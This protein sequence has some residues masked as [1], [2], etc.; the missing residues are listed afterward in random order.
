MARSKAKR[1]TRPSDIAVLRAHLG[2]DD[3]PM[4]FKEFGELLGVSE[5][6]AW[7]L[8][9]GAR[10]PTPMCSRLLGHIAAKAGLDHLGDE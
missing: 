8:E 7:M 10:D 2:K 3:R 9:T 5:Q 6:M 4:T 1:I